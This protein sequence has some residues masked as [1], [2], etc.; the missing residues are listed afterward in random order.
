[1]P[2]A[3]AGNWAVAAAAGRDER[4]RAPGSGRSPRVPAA[5]VHR[6]RGP[7]SPGHERCSERE[8]RAAGRTPDGRSARSRVRR[9]SSGTGSSPALD[10][11]D[12]AV[13]SIGHRWC[14]GLRQS[15]GVAAP[16][17]TM[18]AAGGAVEAA[19]GAAAG[20]AAVAA[21]HTESDVVAP[22]PPRIARTAAVA[23]AEAGDVAAVRTGGVTGDD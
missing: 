14:A 2:A 5:D 12:A 20:A 18:A 11:R 4:V 7:G 16:G 3:V 15:G 9:R 8:R 23:V 21:E 22:P 17:P 6:M 10:E 19:A 1:M 13:A